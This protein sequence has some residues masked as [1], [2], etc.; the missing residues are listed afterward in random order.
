MIFKKVLLIL[1]AGVLL[2][3]C[4]K[5]T[6]PT[7]E[8]EV[9]QEAIEETTETIEEIATE[10]E[11]ESQSMEF[12]DAHGNL[13]TMEI[14]PDVKHH[15]YDWSNLTRKDFDVQYEDDT[16]YIRRGIDVSHHQGAVDWEKVKASGYEFAIVR[17]VYS[18]LIWEAEL[19]DIEQIQ[20]YPVWYADYEPQPQTPY[21]FM[22]WQYS[23]TG[24]VDGIDGYVDLNIQFCRK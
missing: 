18:N 19:F 3:G 7:S 15:P 11:H 5:E 14:N 4:G 6:L 23:E 9:T 10:T 21:D 2:S 24:I 16:Y 1:G 8:T 13:H 20:Q 12:L 22:F 17:L